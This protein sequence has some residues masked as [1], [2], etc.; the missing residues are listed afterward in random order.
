VLTAAILDAD[1]VARRL[2]GRGLRRDRL[3]PAGADPT[4][5][6]AFETS[7]IRLPG[8]LAARLAAVAAQIAMAQPGQYVCPPD[9]LHV[10][11]CGPTH[12]GDAL[13]VDAA[14]DDLRGRA[15]SLAGCRLRVVRLGV[16]DT[17]IF[18]GIEASGADLGAVR[19]ALV[20]GWDVPTRGG[21]A[22]LVTDRMF[23]ANLVRFTEPPSKA[24]VT[25]ARR[26]RRVRHAGFPVTTI[27]L[28]RTNRTMA[29]GETTTLGSVEVPAIRPA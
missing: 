1:W 19:R 10:T 3:D 11:V 2:I 21:P 22:S 4:A 6:A 23:W 15:P 18:A 13:A 12:L 28:V 9:T 14:L 29:P 7:V 8:P 26:H 17:S 5:P 27:E 20:R 25:A 24:L 16:G